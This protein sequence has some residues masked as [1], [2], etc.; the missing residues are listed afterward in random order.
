MQKVSIEQIRKHFIRNITADP[1]IDRSTT[2]TPSEN[3]KLSLAYLKKHFTLCSTG[4]LAEDRFYP[5]ACPARENY[6]LVSCNGEVIGLHRVVWALHNNSDIP[7]GM[8]IGHIDRVKSNN[9]PDNL[10][11][12][13]AAENSQN[14]LTRPDNKVGY[15]GVSFDPPTGRYRVEITVKGRTIRLGRFDTKDQAIA[16]RVAAEK[17]YHPFAAPQP[18]TQR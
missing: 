1:T 6:T 2:R 5:F 13:T 15:R 3:L 17:V 8:Q 14:R 18:K 12:V 4:V 9:H 7:V 11:L 10:R 16:A